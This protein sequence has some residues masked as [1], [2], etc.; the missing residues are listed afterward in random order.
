MSI[1]DNS[2]F[3]SYATLSPMDKIHPS[4]SIVIA[5][6]PELVNQRS[7]ELWLT[8]RMYRRAR[9]NPRRVYSSALVLDK[10]L[11]KRFLIVLTGGVV[12]ET[13]EHRRVRRYRRGYLGLRNWRLQDRQSGIP[14]GGVGGRGGGVCLVLQ[15]NRRTLLAPTGPH[16]DIRYC[17]GTAL[18][19]DH[20]QHNTTFESSTS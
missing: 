8:L 11:S 12:S 10:R 16:P 5:H 20:A 18:C 7:T 6:H 14:S 1:K 13:W 2:I 15:R 9:F 4:W 17:D 3:H 19:Y